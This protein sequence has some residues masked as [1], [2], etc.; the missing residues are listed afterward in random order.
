MPALKGQ[1]IM[2]AGAIGVPRP[3]LQAQI[4]RDQVSPHCV[5]CGGSMSAELRARFG[6]DTHIC[7]DPHDPVGPVE[8]AACRVAI[9]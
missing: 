8:L 4:D 2:R 9:A 5:K 3:W 6:H 1:E 7:C